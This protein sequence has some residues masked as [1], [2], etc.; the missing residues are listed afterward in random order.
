MTEAVAYLSLAAG[1]VAWVALLILDR[2][3][4]GTWR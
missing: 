1:A 4:R 3:H 2:H